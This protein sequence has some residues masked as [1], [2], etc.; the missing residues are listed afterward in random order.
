MIR[1]NTACDQKGENKMLPDKTKHAMRRSAQRNVPEE[2][3]EYIIRYGERFQ[4][5]G[6]TIYYLRSRD[7]PEWDRA[8]DRWAKLA[9]TALVLTQEG[10][11]IL[12]TWRNRK[13]GLKRI[14]RKPDYGLSGMDGLR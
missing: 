4:K 9:G 14:K 2:A 12:T 6:A 13:N 7:I 8:V 1:A 5:A 11:T 3:M 10:D